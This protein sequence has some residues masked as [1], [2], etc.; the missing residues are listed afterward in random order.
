VVCRFYR[1]FYLWEPLEEL[2]YAAT[3]LEANEAALK[4]KAK[5]V[6]TVIRRFNLREGMTKEDERLPPALHRALTDSGKV[7]TADEL[8]VM[9]K[10]YYRLHGWDET[11]LPVSE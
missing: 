4:K 5:A 2:V 1:D 11:G 8:E 3:G 7:I 9:L 10:D 6:A